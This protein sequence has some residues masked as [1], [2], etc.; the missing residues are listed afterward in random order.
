MN[1]ASFALLALFA[2]PSQR[3]ADE[4]MPIALIHVEANVGGASGG[5]TA[6][7]VGDFVYHYQQSDDP[8]LRVALLRLMRDD[9][10]G[11]RHVYAGLQNRTLH[12]AHL[13]LS[14]EDVERIA[15]R[16]SLAYV[17]QEL[18][19]DRARRRREDVRWFE[20]LRDRTELP[21]LRGA[22]LLQP[23]VACDEVDTSGSDAVVDSSGSEALWN[24]VAAT[25]GGD[26]LANELGRV[27]RA[28]AEF[29]LEEGA[30]DLEPLRELL[31]LRE[32]LRALDERW[33][34]ARAAAV[35]EIEDVA[36]PEPFSA[37]ERAA[38]TRFRDAQS[39]AI[40]ALLRSGRP[41]RGLALHVAIARHRALSRSLHCDR[42]IV[43]DPF[44]DS[45]PRLP[46]ETESERAAQA[47]L[48]VRATALAQTVRDALADEQ[49]PAF[50]EARFNHLEDVLARRREARRGARGGLV[51]VQVGR[52]VPSHGRSVAWPFALGSCA[53][54]GTDFDE[55]AVTARALCEATE[56]GIADRH[57]YALIDRNCVTELV[58]LLDSAFPDDAAAAAALGARLEPGEDLAFIPWVF[59]E[60][61]VSRLR[62]EGV[63]V[64]LS[65]RLESLARLE[66]T[67]PGVLATMREATTLASTIYVPRSSDGEFLFFTDDVLWQRPL[68]G[69]VNLGY[70][71]GHGVVGVFTAPFDGGRRFRA[72]IHG[73]FFSLPELVFANV[74]KGSFDD[75]VD[76]PES[77]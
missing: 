47:S 58:C 66:A 3:P 12:L 51:R 54:D 33:P 53:I 43:L 25:L 19:F 11:F 60:D 73:A 57:G 23:A 45:A 76:V 15:R 20:A 34:L 67:K 32:A 14:S 29:R 10:H 30:T 64:I 56:R 48:A 46:V 21:P 40:L 18:E 9:W 63:E 5:H 75:V 4:R 49:A 36:F 22:G 41:D 26:F 50:D 72:G 77:R 13:D 42:W 37:R 31:T 7:R 1:P 24:D 71:L 52:M 8:L 68:R 17:E 61:A 27:E 69:V 55:R 38:I 59:H 44:P 6:I 35:D 39:A 62:I 65:H 28:L 70:G 2:L 16:F 74:R